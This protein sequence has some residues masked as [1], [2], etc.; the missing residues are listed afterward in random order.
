[1]CEELLERCRAVLEDVTTCKELLPTMDGFFFGSTAYDNYYI[2]D[3]ELV[4]HKLENNI[5]PAFDN[6]QDT[7]Y[8]T[9]ETWY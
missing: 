5:L 1:M 3:I 2:Q 7:E 9:F 4:V 6:L 8:I